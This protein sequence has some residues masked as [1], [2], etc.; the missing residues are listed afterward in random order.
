MKKWNNTGSIEY[1][2]ERF[3]RVSTGTYHLKDEAPEVEDPDWKGV[4]INL[5]IYGSAFYDPGKYY[6][7]PENCYP[8]EQSVDI[9]SIYGPGEIDWRT[10]LSAEEF[11][12]IE[13]KM[14]EACRDDVG[15]F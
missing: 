2:L 6:G 5:E 9:E 4:E 10:M 14:F 12:D 8:E 15:Q 3:F 13:E 1:N 11:K 7:P